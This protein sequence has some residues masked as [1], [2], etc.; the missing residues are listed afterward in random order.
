MSVKLAAAA[1]LMV[2]IPAIAADALPA[3]K[4]L[5]NGFY[6]S[7]V[8]L[9]GRIAK[10]YMVDTIAQICFS[11]NVVIPCENLKMRDEWKKIITWVR[12]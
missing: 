8:D 9:D 4:A 6:V 12:E 11:T 1:G 2:S 5:R 7:T 10:R 3:V